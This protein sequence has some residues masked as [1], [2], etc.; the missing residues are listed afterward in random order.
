MVEGLKSVRK[1]GTMASTMKI[2]GDIVGP[3]GDE[4]DWEAA[5]E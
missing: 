2:A 4:A 3:I 5:R 1:F